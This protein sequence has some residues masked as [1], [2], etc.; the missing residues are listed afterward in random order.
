MKAADEATAHAEGPVEGCY[1]NGFFLEGAAWDDDSSTLRESDPKVI[2]V[3]LPVMHF[4]PKYTAAAKE[5]QDSQNNS[6]SQSQRN[7]S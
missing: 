1:L 7:D 4:I 3:P 2:H 5:Q 6:R